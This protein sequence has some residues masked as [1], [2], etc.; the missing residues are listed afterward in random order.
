MNILDRFRVMPEKQLEDARKEL[1]ASYHEMMKHYAWK[2]L[3]E[4]I[5]KIYQDSYRTEDQCDIRELTVGIAA[6][7]RGKRNAIDE[8]RR[9]INSAVGVPQ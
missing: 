2:H 6:E 3:T 8:I 9:K 1:A 7:A 5:E 4:Q